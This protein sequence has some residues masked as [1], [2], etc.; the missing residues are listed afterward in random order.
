[1]LDTVQASSSATVTVNADNAGTS[2]EVGRL[3]GY[4][5]LYGY[6]LSAL[7]EYLALITWQI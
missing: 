1:M 7:V 2:G 5:C 3:Q 6:L 4:C